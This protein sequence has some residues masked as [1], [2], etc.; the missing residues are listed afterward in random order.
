MESWVRSNCA[1]LRSEAIL[2][3]AVAMEKGRA[4]ALDQSHCSLL[5]EIEGELERAVPLDERTHTNPSSG[6]ANTEQGC[7][8]PSVS[9]K[10]QL[11]LL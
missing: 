11:A 8:T 4:L 3:N 5:E 2:R 10:T 1:A 9:G 6:Q 7:E